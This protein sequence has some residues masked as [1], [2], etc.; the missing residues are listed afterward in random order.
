MLCASLRASLRRMSSA[1]TTSEGQ[2]RL[3]PDLSLAFVRHA[4]P[5]P[6]AGAAPS[7][8]ALRVLCAHGW[9]DNSA[10]F[11]L[12]APALASRLRAEVVC[13]DLAGHGR[14]GHRA[15]SAVY[16]ALH[17]AADLVRACEELGWAPPASAAAAT[18]AWL[19]LST[20]ASRR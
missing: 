7:A 14:S 12:L 6:A 18:Q 19:R 3:S 8:V 4:P 10:T 17:S 2:L 16:S 9:C 20:S 15:A 5:A 11:A 13:V 1:A